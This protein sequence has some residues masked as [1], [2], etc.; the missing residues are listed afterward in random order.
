MARGWIFELTPAHL[1]FRIRS[2][3]NKKKDLV[4]KK[5]TLSSRAASFEEESVMQSTFVV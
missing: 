1:N 5:A 2:W 3:K 4:Q